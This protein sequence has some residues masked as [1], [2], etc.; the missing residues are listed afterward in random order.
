MHWSTFGQPLSKEASLESFITRVNP[1][2]AKQTL[3]QFWRPPGKLQ[4][5]FGGHYRDSRV[6]LEAASVL[7][8]LHW[9]R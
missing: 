6:F 9:K 4:G 5:V 2:A 3:K 1:A 8:L 7:H